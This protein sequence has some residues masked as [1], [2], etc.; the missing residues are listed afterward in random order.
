METLHV[1]IPPSLQPFLAERTAERGC[2]DASQYIVSLI[3]ADQLERDRIT[4]IFAD[5]KNR[6]RIERLLDE[7][8]ASPSAPLDMDAIRREVRERREARERDQTV[9][10]Q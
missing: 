6:E 1:T 4:D 7:G 2:A 10:K 3:L 5:E 8:L 9:A